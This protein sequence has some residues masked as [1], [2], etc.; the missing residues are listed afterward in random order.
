MQS[1]TGEIHVLPGAAQRLAGRFG[2]RACAPAATLTVDV[3][4]SGGA[5]NEIAVTAGRTGEV[6]LR[7]PLFSGPYRLVDATTGKRV[8]PKGHGDTVSFT[9]HKGHK[10]LATAELRFEIAAPATLEVG[11]SGT[12]AVTVHASG[13]STVP[14]STL[15]LV[16]PTGW[17]AEPAQARVGP[18]RPG[19]WQTHRFTV[20][21]TGEAAPGR[22]RIGV[23]LVHDDAWQVSGWTAIDLPVPPPCARPDPASPI[24]AWD[25]TSG[26]TVA[27]HSPNGRTATAQGGAAYVADGPTGSALVLDGDRFLRTAP[28][29]LGFVETA[30]FAAEVKVTTS[31]T[32]RRLFD[33]QPS[34]DP[35]TDGVLIDITPSNQVRFIGSGTGVTSNATVPLGRYIDL[36][37]TMDD[38]GNITVYIDGQ[39]AGTAKVPDGGI[40]GCATRELRF[41][42]DQNGGQRLTGEVDRMAILPVA[43]PADQVGTWQTRAFG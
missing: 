15:R 24:V 2:L 17:S 1:Q 33:F 29:T 30:T 26:D 8:N 42:A 36:V 27:D 41:G 31:G 16:L 21:P 20:T 9:A 5:A 35:G 6:T 19:R 12:V 23:R 22:N 40:V 11:E 18:L 3:A 38:D 7:S 28:T 10:Y 39:Q 34:G 25:P 4:W 14:A 32:Y 43:L 37:V 13:A